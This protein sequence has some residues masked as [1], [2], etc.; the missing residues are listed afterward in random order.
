MN[1]QI[2]VLLESSIDD[3]C[4]SRIFTLILHCYFVE[5]NMKY[6]GKIK[7]YL[8]NSFGWN[9]G[10]E[11][12]DSHKGKL[13][14]ALLGA[15]EYAMIKCQDFNG[16]AIAPKSEDDF[17]MTRN[18]VGT[19]ERKIGM[20]TILILEHLDSYQRRVLIDSR[21]NFIVPDKQLY[22]PTFG[23]LMQERSLG[24]RQSSQEKLSAVAVA[25][26][27]LQLAKGTLNGK[28][29]SQVAEIM[30]YSIKTLSLAVNELA[31][32]G[33]IALRQEGR[34]K[35]LDFTLL[36]KQMWDKIYPMAESPIER[37]MFTADKEMAAEIGIRASDS[38]LSEVSMLIPPIQEV[39]AVYARNPRLKEL[40]LNVSDGSA[41]IEIWKTDPSLSAEGGNADIFSL[42]LTYK[43]DDDPRVRKELEK[44]INE[45]L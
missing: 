9:V 42:A 30:G 6:E 24:V 22:L 15:A 41:I 2:G 1:S 20:P 40:D 36:P 44:I 8:Q 5:V 25:V 45:K 35:L 39:Y 3:T 27:I 34:K 18:L 31:Q 7:D 17:R 14:Y 16:V 32:H 23:I 33:L 4:L 29:V 28:S 11:S 37:R 43:E 21:I 12:F 19:V 38:A 26:I 10:F 13:P